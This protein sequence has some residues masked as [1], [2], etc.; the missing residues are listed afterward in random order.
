MIT[1]EFLARHVRA[2][3]STVITCNACGHWLGRVPLYESEGDKGDCCDRCGCTSV[4]LRNGRP[5]GPRYRYWPALIERLA[6]GFKWWTWPEQVAMF[7]EMG[8]A[9]IFRSMTPLSGGAE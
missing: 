1:A 5:F 9:V 8:E 3:K 6:D 4:R 2:I 7:P